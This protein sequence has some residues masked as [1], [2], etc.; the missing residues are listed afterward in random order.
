MVWVA[1]AGPGI[2]I[3]LALLSAALI[4]LAL[5]L[6]GSL[7]GWAIDNLRHSILINL[8]LVVFNMIPLPP[9]DG[10]RI[11]VGLLPRR[12]AGPLS[13]MERFGLPVIIGVLFIVP[14]AGR[15]LSVDLNV[16]P[17]LIGA[18]VTFLVDVVAGMT[19]LK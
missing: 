9:L 3:V 7:Q 8:V 6:P 5:L 10:G 15:G 13:G 18:P 2:N 4:H 11:A 16:F 17:W 12:L 19:G 14:W 1:A